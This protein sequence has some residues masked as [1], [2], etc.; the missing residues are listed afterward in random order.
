MRSIISTIFL[1]SF[2]KL[3]IF[4]ASFPIIIRSPTYNTTKMVEFVVS[5]MYTFRSID[6]LSNMLSKK[7]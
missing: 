1:R 6:D 7:Y 5:L 4:G 3:S 2:F